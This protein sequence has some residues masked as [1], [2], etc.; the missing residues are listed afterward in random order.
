MKAGK[1][2]D[3]KAGKDGIL[4]EDCVFL[5][6]LQGCAKSIQAAGGKSPLPRASP[7]AQITNTALARAD[8][9]EEPGFRRWKRSPEPPSP[10]GKAAGGGAGDHAKPIGGRVKG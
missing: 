5:K 6:T 9:R 3:M 10:H 8:S 1:G 2:S 7:A 4:R